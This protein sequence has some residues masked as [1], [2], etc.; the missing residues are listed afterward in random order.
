MENFLRRLKLYGIGFG[1]G[2]VCVF[3]FFRNRGCAW[4]PENRVK[5]TILERVIVVHA[6]E[7]KAFRALA[8][9][10]KKLSE[11]IQNADVAFSESKKQ[12]EPKAYKLVGELP[13]GKSID[14][15]LTL[16]E[17]S[18]VCELKLKSAKI[19]QVKNSIEGRGF[20]VLFPKNKGL[21][22]L[23]LD[24]EILTNLRIK[25][26]TKSE[27]LLKIIRMHGFIDFEKSSF[28]GEKPNCCW[29]INHPQHKFSLATFWYKEKIEITAFEE[30]ESR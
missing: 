1:I 10:E 25:G 21:F 29:V 27:Q 7:I 15:I 6:D 11:L 24:K 18:V 13:N 12:G 5:S 17:R 9:N 3:F 28:S 2:L 8:L 30:L 19:K 26:I 23:G 20:P 14:F 4:L 22:Y 16:P